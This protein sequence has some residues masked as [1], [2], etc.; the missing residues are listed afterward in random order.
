MIR[1]SQYR[2]S[3]NILMDDIDVEEI[4]KKCKD[5]AQ[6][7]V[8]K[9]ILCNASFYRYENMGFLYIEEIVE[10]N[11]SEAFDADEFMADL[12]PYLK[13]WPEMDGDKF[14]APMINV[15]FHHIPDLDINEWE[16]E[17]TTA[18]KERIGRVAFVYPDK[19]PSYVMHHNAIVEEGLL[20]GDKYAYIS[21]H[22]NILF[23]YYEE[24]RNNVNIKGL[25]EES[26]VIDNWLKVDPESHFDREKAQGK[27]FLVIPSLFTVDRVDFQ[28]YR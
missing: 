18:V 4:V 15:Y 8:E 22:E 13:P 27:N 16:K 23:S 24:P 17:R 26:K 10:S 12:K 9:K 6:T 19:L 14:F 28:G 1:R 2:C 5:K 3:F 11:D 7:F 25:E 21:L 20:K